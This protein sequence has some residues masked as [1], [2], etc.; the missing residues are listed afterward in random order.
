MQLSGTASHLNSLNAGKAEQ[1]GLN[2]TNITD[3]L[4]LSDKLKSD[5]INYPQKGA[6]DLMS[7]KQPD[8]VF[9][10]NNMD[11]ISPS[12]LVFIDEQNHQHLT[13]II[14]KTGLCYKDSI[15]RDQAES[16]LFMM[17]NSVP[18]A[19]S[20]A[21]VSDLELMVLLPEKENLDLQIIQN[22]P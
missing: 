8:Y 5:L 6:A 12:G 21:M 3:Y 18:L 7:V 17:F 20:L 19:F 13:D 1:L 16:R 11:D 14:M 9:Q 22:T 4:F 15:T 2:R 10:N